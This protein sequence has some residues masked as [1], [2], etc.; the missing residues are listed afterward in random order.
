MTPPADAETRTS[1]AL[2]DERVARIRAGYRELT[3]SVP[4]SIETRLDLAE[5]TG[6]LSA[7]EAIEALRDELIVANPLGRKTGQLVHFAQLV[8]LGKAGPARLHAQAAHRGGASVE[9]LVGVAELALITAGM[10]AYSLGVEIIAELT[11]DESGRAGHGQ[12]PHN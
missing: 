9:E 7:V 1:V 8:A 4:P 10:P 5:H 11:A 3:G 6:R 12:T 2:A